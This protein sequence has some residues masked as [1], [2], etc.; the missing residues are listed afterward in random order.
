[1][2][3]LLRLE[4][5]ERMLLHPTRSESQEILRSLTDEQLEKLDALYEAGDVD[6]AAELLAQA[7]QESDSSV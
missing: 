3:R 5:L 4:R 6:G 7:A 1:V 2:N